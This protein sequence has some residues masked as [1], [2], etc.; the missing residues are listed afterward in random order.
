MPF[1]ESPFRSFD[2]TTFW[3]E[4]NSILI[5]IS[6]HQKLELSF[7]SNVKHSFE[8][9]QFNANLSF[10]IYFKFLT[11]THKTIDWAHL[12]IWMELKNL[13]NDYTYFCKFGKLKVLLIFWSNCDYLGAISC[14]ESCNLNFHSKRV[15][16][17]KHSVPSF[18]IRYK[19]NG[20]NIFSFVTYRLKKSWLLIRFLMQKIMTFY[21]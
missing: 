12:Y 20:P 17:K 15:C 14:T 9:F 21:Q 11:V 18:L 8:F 13:I 19:N 16:L 6:L 4:I 1:I 10:Q 2:K 3:F 7:V 5:L